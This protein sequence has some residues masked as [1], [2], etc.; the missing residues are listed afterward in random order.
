MQADMLEQIRLAEQGITNAYEEAKKRCE[1]ETEEALRLNKE[2]FEEA[3]K[4]LHEEQ[5]EALKACRARN[6]KR[7]AGA[8]AEAS[9]AVLRLREACEKKETVLLEGLQSI[10][11]NS[12]S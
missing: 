11:E 5:E 1:A 10:L 3:M 9:M 2:Q 8:E 7:G 6:E 4:R 12:A